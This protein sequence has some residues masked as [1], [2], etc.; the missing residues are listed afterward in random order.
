MAT[1]PNPMLADL[2]IGVTNVLTTGDV[3]SIRDVACL[4][5][6][7]HTV[8]IRQ[9]AALD[10]KRYINMV[11]QSC[12]LASYMES[13]HEFFAESFEGVFATEAEAERFALASQQRLW[14]LVVV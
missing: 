11:M 12:R 8:V 5:M 3:A 4:L 1:C 14:A 6:Q 2:G 9:R 7:G 10:G 13:A